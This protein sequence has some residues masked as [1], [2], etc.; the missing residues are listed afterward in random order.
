MADQT[1]LFCPYCRPENLLTDEDGDCGHQPSEPYSEVFV[2]THPS[3]MCGFAC[4]VCG[5]DV[6]AEPCPAHAITEVPG[7]RLVE[8]ANTP[9]HWE[10]VH[11]RD[12]YGVPC[13]WCQ[14]A[15]YW[16]RDRLAR[17]C[18]HWPWRRWRSIRHLDRYVLRPLRL[19][20][21]LCW[22]TGD[23]HAGCQ[24]WCWRWSR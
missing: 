23:G 24:T 14:L 12:D 4:S 20:K 5:L 17:Q 16:E 10:W 1:A 11:E 21:G 22:T 9:R 19:S 6:N 13:P 15:V 2:W 18:R 3:G 7:L 8:C